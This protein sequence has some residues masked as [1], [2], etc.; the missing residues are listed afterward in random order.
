MLLEESAIPQGMLQEATIP[1]K[2]IIPPE[3]KWGIGN[4]NFSLSSFLKPGLYN[5]GSNLHIQSKLGLVTETTNNG[6]QGT[7]GTMRNWS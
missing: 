6:S 4:I 5:S 1:E 2:E 3:N 7:C